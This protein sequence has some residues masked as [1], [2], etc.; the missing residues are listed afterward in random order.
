MFRCLG[1]HNGAECHLL[2]YLDHIT[3]TAV[4]CFPKMSISLFPLSHLLDV[5]IKSPSVLSLMTY[6]LSCLGTNPL[7][8]GFS[9]GTEVPNTLTPPPSSHE[10]CFLTFVGVA[11]APSLQ[12]TNVSGNSLSNHLD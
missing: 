4:V 7:D 1:H 2:D 11:A 9:I 12:F 6:G 5:G 10:V 8:K 3:H